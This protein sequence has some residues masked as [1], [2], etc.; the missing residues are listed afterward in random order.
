MGVG[1]SSEEGDLPPWLVENSML[2]P[3]VMDAIN[4]LPENADTFLTQHPFWNGYF[5]VQSE[6]FEQAL[7]CT[8]FT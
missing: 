8:T 2:D 4:A 1:T 6:D 7:P 5:R 3:D